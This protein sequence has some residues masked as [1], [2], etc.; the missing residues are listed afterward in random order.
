M[1]SSPFWAVA[2]QSS[3][4]PALLLLT[5]V[6]SLPSSAF[7]TLSLTATAREVSSEEQVLSPLSTFVSPLMLT[8]TSPPPPRFG[9][10][11]PSEDDPGD[12]VDRGKRRRAEAIASAPDA[13]FY[14]PARVP[15][16]GLLAG[17]IVTASSNP[18]TVP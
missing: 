6:A 18:S 17:I 8:H 13:G 15:S 9:P 10:P 16:R 5:A 14:A 12:S 2:V 3:Y 7:A 4:A 1:S 11:G